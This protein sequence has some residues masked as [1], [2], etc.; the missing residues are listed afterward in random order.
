MVILMKYCK[1]C[2]KLV[3]LFCCVVKFPNRK[4]TRNP[5][6]YKPKHL[7]MSQARIKCPHCNATYNG[8]HQM[9]IGLNGK[10]CSDCGGLIYAHGYHQ[11]SNDAA[12]SILS[13]QYMR[14]GNGGIV[15][16]GIYFATNPDATQRKAH[17]HGSI[18][19][20]DIKLGKT[21]IVKGSDLTLN[22]DKLNKQGYQSVKVLRKGGFWGNELV[23]YDST[24]VSSIKSR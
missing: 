21:K 4:N 8:K 3:I 7:K 24:Q 5:F 18:L 13:S 1:Y 2:I 9:S 14:K 23:A 22:K 20:A 10:Y 15:G 12:N 6:F 16:A 11:T 19:Q 17:Q